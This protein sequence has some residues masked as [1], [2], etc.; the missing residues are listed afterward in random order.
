MANLNH[1]TTLTIDQADLPPAFDT[2]PTSDAP[3]LRPG[4]HQHV[5]KWVTLPAVSQLIYILVSVQYFD[6]VEK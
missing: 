1:Y 5:Y 4:G 2:F 6:D 3:D